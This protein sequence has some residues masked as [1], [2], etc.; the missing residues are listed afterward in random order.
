MLTKSSVVLD[1]QLTIS[2]Y[3]ASICRSGFYQL[4]QLRSIRRSLTADAKRALVQAFITCMLDYC[5]SLLAAF[6]DVHLRRFQ[7]V[8]NAAARLVSGA[9][10]RDHIRPVLANL[11]CL[12]VRKRLTFKTAVL[13]WKCLHD[14]V[15]CCL[16]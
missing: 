7:S 5:N 15:P 10:R 4:R 11:H 8:Q 9:R 13:V 3:T 1:S 14:A 16:M 2:T 6:A 12:P